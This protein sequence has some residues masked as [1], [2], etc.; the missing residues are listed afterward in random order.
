VQPRSR[1]RVSLRAAEARIYGCS[2]PRYFNLICCRREL[3]ILQNG[4]DQVPFIVDD[5]EKRGNVTIGLDARSVR[6]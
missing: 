3:P 5:A 1:I 4:T 2:L 6:G